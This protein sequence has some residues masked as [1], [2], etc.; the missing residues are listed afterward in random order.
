A[1][2]LAEEDLVVG[3]LPD[4]RAAELV[5]DRQQGGGPAGGVLGPPAQLGH[6]GQP[7]LPS[8]GGLGQQRGEQA[9]RDGEADAIGLGGAGKGGQAIVIEEDRVL[10]QRL[11]FSQVRAQGVELFAELL[12]GRQVAGLLEGVQDPLGV[13]IE[14]L[15]GQ[16]LLL[17]ALGNAAG[18]AVRDGG[19]I[20]DAERR[21]GG[22]QWGTW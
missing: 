21:G 13:A 11:Q 4:A 3:R 10:A 1:R 22:G 9:A 8:G 2:L 5:E 16:A 15:A 7:R 14:G 20:G 19:G 12:A 18:G 17:G 6:T